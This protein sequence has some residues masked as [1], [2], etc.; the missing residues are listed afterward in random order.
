MSYSISLSFFLC[1]KKYFHISKLLLIAASADIK[2]HINNSLLE[3]VSDEMVE[4]MF[5]QTWANIP[6]TGALFPGFIS[7]SIFSNFLIGYNRGYGKIKIKLRNI[8]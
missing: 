2:E 4:N 3:L 7:F 1:L 8:L 5:R 6:I